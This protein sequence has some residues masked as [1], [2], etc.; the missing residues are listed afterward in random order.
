MTS[1]WRQVKSWPT[2]SRRSREGVVLLVPLAV[3]TLREN[4]VLIVGIFVSA[5]VLSERWSFPV[6]SEWK[7]RVLDHMGSTGEDGVGEQGE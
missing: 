6:S 2:P 1:S 3:V 5:G 7:D 4:E